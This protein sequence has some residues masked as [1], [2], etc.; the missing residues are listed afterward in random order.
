M[1]PTIA[2]LTD[3]GLE[4]VYVGV[5]KGVMQGICP[6][7]HFIDLTHSI[8]P[9][10]VRQAAF[11]LLNNYRYFQP[12][13]VFLVVVDPGVGSTRKPI[14]VQTEDYCFIAPDN[15]VLT[16]L[17]AEY[18]AYTVVEL[19]NPAYQRSGIS[20]TFH[21]RDIFA[22]VAAHI[23][24]GV[25]LSE[26]GSA[27][28]YVFKQPMPHLNIEGS[29]ITGEIAHIDRFGN[30]ITSIGNL[31]WIDSETLLLSPR[32]GKLRDPM[33]LHTPQISTTI[34]KHTVSQIRPAYSE[35]GR[36]DL[37]MLIGSSG[38]LEI[39]I[40]QGNAAARLGVA[41]GDRIEIQTGA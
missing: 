32:F 19:S 4:D 16:Y 18:D 6:E 40:N 26:L 23:A 10:N 12:G 29:K 7:A 35:V 34:H 5:M 14:A 15:G 30:I 9:Q 17:L 13:T 21:G 27:V 2:L 38:Y 37:L 41:I 36:G 1:N 28:D 25:P 11:T 8:N 33:R 24:A 31:D 3:F 22:P 20:N 39:A